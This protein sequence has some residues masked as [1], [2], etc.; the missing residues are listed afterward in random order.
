LSTNHAVE[1]GPYSLPNPLEDPHKTLTQLFYRLVDPRGRSDGVPAVAASQEPSGRMTLRRA[2]LTG[3]AVCALL[4]PASADSARR[5]YWGAYMDGDPTYVHYYGGQWSDAPWDADTWSKFESNAGKKVSV[6]HWGMAAPWRRSFADYKPTFE[7]VR[8]AGDL[9]A[10]DMSTG[11]VRLRAIARG[12]YDFSL[13]RW[14]RQAAR[15]GHPFFFILDAEMNGPWAPYAPGRNG[16]TA[17]GFVKMWRHFHTLA[18]RAGATN[19][20]WVW[21]PNVDP[22]KQFTPYWRLYPGGAHV[23]WTC[24]D[25]YNHNGT[26]TFSWLFRSSYARLLRIAPRKRVMIGQ[27]GS[28]EGGDGKAEWITAALSGQ[29]PEHFPRVKALLWFNWRIYQKG[30]WWNWPIESSPSGQAAFREAIASPYYVPGGSFGTLPRGSKIRA[31]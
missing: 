15:W 31:P 6:V 30:K 29:L 24:L 14:V 21:C 16:N 23:D 2:L 28:V 10:V 3:L 11:S 7:L 27:T 4:A 17:T 20:T 1:D 13:K 22:R 9:N 8:K 26:Q 19:I 25:G 12:R 18:N 5:I